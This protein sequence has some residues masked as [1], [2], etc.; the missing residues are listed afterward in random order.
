MTT[1][2]IVLILIGIA[3]VTTGAALCIWLCVR[4]FFN[5][6][7]TVINHG[8]INHYGEEEKEESKVIDD[9]ILLL[10]QCVGEILHA[11]REQPDKTPQRRN[12][13]LNK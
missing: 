7:P 8:T 6:K 9:K 2:I 12:R 3:I 11:A 1:D 10:A 13:R 5:A 4:S